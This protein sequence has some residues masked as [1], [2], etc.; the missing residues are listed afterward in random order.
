MPVDS[1]INDLCLAAVSFSAPVQD[2]ANAR[3]AEVAWQAAICSP[4]FVGD[5]MRLQSSS[6][7]VST[8]LDFAYY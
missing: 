4:F 8:R 5:D 1:I 3:R 7:H 6:A 2:V